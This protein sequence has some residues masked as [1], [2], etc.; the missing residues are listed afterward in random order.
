M[1]NFFL[2]F[3]ILIAAFENLFCHNLLVTLLSVAD[4]ERSKELTRSYRSRIYEL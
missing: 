2:G 4:C 3:I 1:N